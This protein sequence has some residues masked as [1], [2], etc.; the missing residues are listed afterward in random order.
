MI[1]SPYL[2]TRQSIQ[3]PNG[4][5]SEEDSSILHMHHAIDVITNVFVSPV[6]SASRCHQGR[7]T[8][9]GDGF[10]PGDR[11]R[12]LPASCLHRGGQKAGAIN[13]SSWCEYIGV[14]CTSP[15]DGKLMIGMGYL[16]GM[17]ETEFENIW[18][19]RPHAHPVQVRTVGI[20]LKLAEKWPW[21]AA[22]IQWEWTG[23]RLHGEF[24]RG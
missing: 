1:G 22:L 16:T 17:G 11:W 18:K 5:G 2:C 12:V 20:G 19:G 23:H 3:T 9:C 14:F 7:E 8:C 15:E 21:Q 4:V 13:T 6:F 10:F 24:G